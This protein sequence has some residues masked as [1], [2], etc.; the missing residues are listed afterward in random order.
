MTGWWRANAVPLGVLLVLVPATTIA[1]GW[2]E[3]WG[4]YSGRASI[5]IAVEAGDSTE[6]AHATVGP[7][8]AE[9]T[10]RPLA[11]EDARVV[12]VRILIDPH[13]LGFSCAIP[14]LRELEGSQRQWDA[15]SAYDLDPER[16]FDLRESCDSET[17]APYTLDLDYLVPLDASGPFT[18]EVTSAERIPEFARLIVEP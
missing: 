11:P 12:A 7:A 1:V 5:P 15:A 13:G 8:T 10:D 17:A 18:V 4:Y 9:F 14:Q 16:D 3:W 6:Y 2:N